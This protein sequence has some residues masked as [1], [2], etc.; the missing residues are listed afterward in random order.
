[1]ELHKDISD[2]DSVSA[3]KPS[4]LPLLIIKLK[5]HIVLAIFIEH[6]MHYIYDDCMGVGWGYDK[7][8]EVGEW[9]EKTALVEDLATLL[10]KG[11][12]EEERESR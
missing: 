8:G 12:K 2:G 11:R 4:N 5:I 9:R 6:K 10:Y 7:G 3:G 1:M